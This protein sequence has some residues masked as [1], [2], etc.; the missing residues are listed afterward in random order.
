MADVD[1]I[2]RNGMVVDG[3]GNP[4]VRMDVAIKDGRIVRLG[5][6]LPLTGDREINAEGRV[7]CPG[8]IDPHNHSDLSVLFNPRA[9]SAV[10]QGVTTMIVGNCGISLAPVNPERAEL[11]KRHLSPFIP[12]GAELK[13]EWRSFGE[14]L[15]RVEE[16]GCS[17]NLA[18]LVGH[19]TIRIYVMGVERREPTVEELEEMKR[20]VA[21]SME[22]GALGLSTGL[23]YPPGMFSKTQEL[24]ELAR[25]VARYGGVYA[26]HIRGEGDTLIEAVE[27]AIQI[28]EEAGVP[29][30]ISHHKASG[31]PNWG[32]SA[33]TLRMMEEARMRGVDV[34]CDQ[35]PYEAGM[36]S[37]ATLLPPWAHE[38]GLERLLE[39]LRRPEERERMR[40]DI[41]QGVPGW[42]NW[43]RDCGWENIY[44][45]SVKTERNRRLEGKSLA[46][47]AEIR[48]EDEFTALCNLLLEEEGAVLIVLFAMCEEDVRRILKHP[49]QM[50]GT[51]SW[52]VTPHVGKP[53]PRFYGTYPRILGRYVRD[54]GL[55]RLEEAIRK[56]TSFPAQ[57]FGLKG[58]GLIRE[59][60]YADIVIF[61]PKR[62]ID[63]ATYKNPHQFPE[64]IEYVLVNGKPVVEEGRHTG[65]LPG[66]V[67]R[68]GLG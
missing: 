33:Q 8:F 55:L 30:Q 29:V 60:F 24:I 36:T 32:R 11:L 39:R 48:G 6:S 45:S 21:E 44:I 22:E 23:I 31:R 34:T 62:V 66:S 26:S 65:I 59:G 40:R 37:L 35:Y 15:R 4:W 52:A 67:I 1:V 46:E 14:Y 25:V 61:D 49:L 16:G 28:G 56:M 19:G 17:C 20:L 50:V 18:S 27:E 58:R 42:Q 47:A 43:V 10:M 51:D 63:R 3:S 64:G 54:E 41:E 2:I 53:H 13:L 38:G 57:R 68:H 7:V 9:E 5:R 12:P